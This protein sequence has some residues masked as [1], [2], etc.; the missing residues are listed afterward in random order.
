MP[1]Q[2]INGKAFEYALL[3]EFFEKLSQRTK[4]NIIENDQYKSG[5]SSFEKIHKE[6][7]GLFRLSASF[8]VNFLQDLEPRLHDDCDPDDILELELLSDRKGVAGDVRDL[9]IIRSLQNWE[10]G[11]SAKNNHDAVKHSRL[12]KKLNFGKKWFGV[13]CTPRYFE[14]IEPI[15]DRLKQIKT[16]S[17]GVKKWKEIGD[18]HKDVYLPVLS[19]FKRELENLYKVHQIAPDL[20][21]YLVGR[22]DFYKII[23]R[24]HNVTIKA[25]NINGELN[26]SSLRFEPKLKIQQVKLPNKIKSIAFKEGS[27]NTLIIDFNNDWSISM[28]IHNAS[29]RV[30]PSLKFDVSLLSSPHGL[31]SNEL[32]TNQVIS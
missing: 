14:E 26:Q 32:T 25:F 27:L 7:Q 9:I 31:F 11:I 8:G 18:Y 22:R 21:R 2:A 5:K 10:I 29:S 16:E 13:S 28:R 30:E 24:K 12:S 15:F 1:T 19:A 4:V 17:Q 3:V 23:R 20:I 6:Q